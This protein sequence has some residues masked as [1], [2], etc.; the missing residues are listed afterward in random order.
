MT[1]TFNVGDKVRCLET[2]AGQFTRG[3]I[4]TVGGEYYGD[5]DPLRV[6]VVKDD[7][8]MDNGW[9]ADRFQLV[10]SSPRTIARDL[11]LTPMSKIL[12][13]HLERHKTISPAEAKA[14]YGFP[15]IARQIWELRQDGL[16]IQT[17]LRK[18]PKGQ[19]YARYSLVA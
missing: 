13:L 2:Y 14:V 6:A 11:S 5:G 10:V 18:D 4:Y 19:R 16:N 9:D 15:K 17:E 8:G 3:C 12:M 7:L 1:Q